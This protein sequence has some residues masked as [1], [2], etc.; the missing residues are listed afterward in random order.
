[1]ILTGKA[2]KDAVRE[3]TIVIDPFCED[4]LNPNSYNF[5]LGDTLLVYQ[6]KVLDVKEP[7]PTR[8]VPIDSDGIVLRPGELYLGHSK[9]QMGSTRYV[10]LIF[11]RSS[12]GRLGIFVQITAP[13][14]DI[15]FQGRWTLQL[16][17]VQPIRV[18]AD[19]RIGQILF[20]QADGPIDLYRGKYQGAS[21]PRSSM[22]HRD[23]HDPHRTKNSG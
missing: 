7:Q 9:E 16:T 3:G 20:F 11:G 12:T 2:I 19:M 6:N 17:V 22:I 1:M 8:T 18:Y 10:P 23:F 21:G 15:G 14:G 13:L 5:H 4:A